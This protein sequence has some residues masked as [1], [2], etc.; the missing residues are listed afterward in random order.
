LQD[1]P[2]V[3]AAAGKL[4]LGFEVVQAGTATEIDA[5]FATLARERAQALMVAS[6]AFLMWWTAPARADESP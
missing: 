3:A 1:I 5:A 2:T 6:D 4:G